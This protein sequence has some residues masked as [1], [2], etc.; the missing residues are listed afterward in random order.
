MNFWS[1]KIVDKNPVNS[2]RK[3]YIR[4]YKD[5]DEGQMRKLISVEEMAKLINSTLDV[6]DKAIITLLAKT[7]I[8]C[9]EL[10]TLDVDDIDW[11]E[12]SIRLKPTP[13]RTNRTVFFDDE[14]AI[15]LHR[16]IKAREARNEKGSKSIVY[17][18]LGG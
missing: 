18:N 14:T 10:I 16:W 2:V 15:V 4:R 6:R 3:R 11:I 12:Q 17:N 8:R 13:K 7:G 5:N 1:S 9:K